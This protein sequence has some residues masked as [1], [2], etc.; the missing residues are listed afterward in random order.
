[1]L[2][3]VIFLTMKVTDNIVR[4]ATAV[5]LN[6]ILIIEYSVPMKVTAEDTTEVIPFPMIM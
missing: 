6:E 4:I 2:S 5:I 1:M 3:I